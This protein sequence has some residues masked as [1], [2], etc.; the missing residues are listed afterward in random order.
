M[1]NVEDINIPSFGI[2]YLFSIE[3]MQVTKGKMYNSV[4]RYSV[5][6]IRGK[7]SFLK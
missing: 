7:L 1:M 2:K 4:A 6:C 5:I 3:I